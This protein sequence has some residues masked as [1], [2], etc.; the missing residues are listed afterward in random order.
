MS[1]GLKTHL[2]LQTSHFGSLQWWGFLLYASYVAM[3]WPLL[4]WRISPIS[5]FKMSTDF[6][7]FL[8]IFPLRICP[9]ASGRGL[10]CCF[11]AG[12]DR[13][14]CGCIHLLC[15]RELTG[16]KMKICLRFSAWLF[17]G[18]SERTLSVLHIHIFPF[19]K[20][21]RMCYGWQLA[22]EEPLPYRCR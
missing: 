18:S 12:F 8:P 17:G 3:V 6:S 13:F 9:L 5:R 14:V 7:Y 20:S 19:P 4:T 1:L 16:R 15:I 11:D 22:N 2:C 10:C 21:R